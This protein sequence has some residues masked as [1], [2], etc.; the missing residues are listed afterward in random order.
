MKPVVSG[1][2]LM[3][4]LGISASQGSVHSYIVANFA[5][6]RTIVEGRTIAPTL[7]HVWVPGY[8]RWNGRTYLWQRGRWAIPP[9]GDTEWVA[10][11]WR[12][13]NDGWLFVEG[14]WR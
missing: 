14:H 3:I 7:R 13:G 4:Y 6:P 11:K 12:H 1:L 2:F 5:P 8:Y 10:S 9:R